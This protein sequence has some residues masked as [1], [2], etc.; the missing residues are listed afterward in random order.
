MTAIRSALVT[1]GTGFIG[2]HLV[3]RLVAEGVTTY[4]L[5]RAKSLTG[6]VAQR[7]AP[8]RCLP[9]PSDSLEDWGT[10]L[11][12]VAADVVFHLASPGV[13]PGTDPPESLIEGNVR[14]ICRLLT[15]VSQWPVRNIVHAGSFSEY[16]PSDQILTEAAPLLPTTPYGASKAAAWIAGRALALQLGLP[17]VN[18]R[19]FH[20]YGPGESPARLIPHLHEPLSRGLPAPLTAGEQMRDL[21]YIDD[22]V[23]ALWAAAS[24]PQTGEPAAYNVCSGL[25]ITIRQIGGLVAQ[26]MN[27]PLSLLRWGDLPYRPGEPMRAVGDNRRFAQATGWRRRVGLEEGIARSLEGLGWKRHHRIAG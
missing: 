12:G 24:L 11:E 26:Q 16:A 25:P 18:L 13:L 20:V 8:A 19:L 7:L 21:V 23:E 4:C 2:G 17:L 6:E 27:V 3:R 10:A 5:V 15:A 9:L 1:G 14:L 22:V